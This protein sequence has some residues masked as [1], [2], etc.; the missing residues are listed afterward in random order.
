MGNIHHEECARFFGNR[1]ELIE[2]DHTRICA[3]TRDDQFRSVFQR[4]LPNVFIV[5]V[6]SF[7]HTV[8]NEIVEFSAGVDCRAVRK[9]ATV[10]QLHAQNLIARLENGEVCGEVCTRTAVRLYVDVV[11]RLKNFFP[12]LYAI[13]F[14]LVHHFATA[15]VAL[16]GVSFAVLVGQAAADRFHDV[17]TAKIFTRDQFDIVRL[18]FFFFF[19]P[20]K[21]DTHWSFPFCVY[22]CKFI[23]VYQ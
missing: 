2:F 7:V 19:D 4:F 16:A 13:A 6:P 21:Y 14:D 8:E 23:T 12:F 3:C 15:V 18:S 5:D 9:V 22:Y 20:F 1:T 10:V 17:V 11:V